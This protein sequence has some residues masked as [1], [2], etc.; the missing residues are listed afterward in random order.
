[1]RKGR[2]GTEGGAVEWKHA[3]G[4]GCKVTEGLLP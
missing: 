3:F 2:V 1:M 4:H